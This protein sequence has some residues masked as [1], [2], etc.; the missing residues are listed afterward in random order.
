MV[1]RCKIENMKKSLINK[2]LVPIGNDD[3]EYFQ[4]LDKHKKYI[5]GVYIGYPEVPSG[6]YMKTASQVFFDKI[7]LWCQE[8]DKV[9]DILF[10]MQAN[11]YYEGFDLKKINLA[12]YRSKKTELT[13]A[14]VILSEEKV[15][16]GLKKNISVNYKNNL[17]QQVASLR[18]VIPE[19]SSIIIDRDINR[20][21]K[22]I[23]EINKFS[24][25]NRLMTDLLITEGCIPFCP[26]K[27]D[28]NIFITSDHL[29]PQ[30][31]NKMQ[32]KSMEVCKKFYLTDISNIL[33]APF[34]TREALIS[35]PGRFF[36]IAGRELSADTIDGILD[37]YINNKPIDIGMVFPVIK[38]RTGVT[39]DLLPQSFHE[40]IL[41][42]K[43]ECY[44]CNFCSIVYKKMLKKARK[45]Q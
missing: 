7:F 32:K 1:I 26:H 23:I 17:V 35:Y 11:A 14:S 31:G 4:L 38:F 10:N 39:T 12:P 44:K 29:F 42:C 18:K 15:F 5:G 20:D 40:K 24:K 6:R 36:K 19:L 34:L 25:K 21:L 3:N 27:I 33:K 37:Y 22:K 45:Y 9:F 8:H 28:H 2:F 43:N 30:P 13:F 41:H 16:K